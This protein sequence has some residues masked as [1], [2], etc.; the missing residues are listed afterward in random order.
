MHKN[1][2]SQEWLNW[3]IRVVMAKN[4]IDNLREEAMK[5]WAEKLAQGWLPAPPPPGYHTVVRDG[6]RIHEPNP[7]TYRTMQKAFKYYLGPSGSIDSVAELM[8]KSGIVTRGGRPYS[9]SAV[10]RL[11]NNPFYIG[12]NFFDGKSYPG[13]QTPLITKRMF[14]KVQDKLHGNATRNNDYIIR[15][16][17]T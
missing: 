12:I 17:K 6:K 11:L 1:S 3:G 2:R 8:A 9:K 14:D 15:Y 16:L 4:Y 7:K 10:H 5:G 13:K